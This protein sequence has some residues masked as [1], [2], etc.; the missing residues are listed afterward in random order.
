MY[1]V[2]L[3][4]SENSVFSLIAEGYF[5]K[6]IP[7][8]T[9]VFSAGIALKK[10][11]SLAIKLMKEDNIDISGLTQH[12]LSDLRH[13]DF[14]YILTFDPESEAESHHLPSKPVKYHYDFE[15][16]LMPENGKNT[17]EKYQNVRDQIKK[18]I[19]SFIKE[20]FNKGTG[21]K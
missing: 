8:N 15:K 4:C 19:R 16:I 10:I 3:L 14:D 21:F 6:Y 18:I 2:L 20:H 7:E 1:R 11:N 17:E 9:E 13:I 5:R 12:I